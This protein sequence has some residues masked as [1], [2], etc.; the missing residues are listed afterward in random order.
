MGAFLELTGE[1]PMS[2]DLRHDDNAAN[3]LVRTV[4]A[5]IAAPDRESQAALPTL[6]LL[7]P[8]LFAGIWLLVAN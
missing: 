1:T 6:L 4:A 7:I 3:P 8:C 5:Q 2:T